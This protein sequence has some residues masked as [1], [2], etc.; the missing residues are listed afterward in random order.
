MNMIVRIKQNAGNLYADWY[1]RHAGGDHQSAML[2]SQKAHW[3]QDHVGESGTI[4]GEIQEN[5]TIKIGNRT[6]NIPGYCLEYIR[7]T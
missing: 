4:A 6:E 2:A 1:L 5:N 3:L 7:W